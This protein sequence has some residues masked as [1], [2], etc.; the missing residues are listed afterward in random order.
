MGRLLIILG[1]LFF[2]LTLTANY[3]DIS[4]HLSGWKGVTQLGELWYYL[5]P[6]SLQISETIISR[7]IDPCST[8]KIL[9]CSGFLWHP[10]ISSIL[11]LPAALFLSILSFVLIFL[12][13]KKR[14]NYQR[15]AK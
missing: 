11:N 8:V 2:V 10:I 3:F 5:A 6:E 14:K 4:L 9:N 1:M 15:V 13:L 7:Y 12:G